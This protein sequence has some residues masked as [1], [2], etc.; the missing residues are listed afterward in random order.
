MYDK[1]KETLTIYLANHNL[2]GLTI[3]WNMKCFAF[4]QLLI[5]VFITSLYQ[6][7]HALR[8]ELKYVDF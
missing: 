2:L 1:K 8:T 4:S 7:S 3:I 5:D 6:K